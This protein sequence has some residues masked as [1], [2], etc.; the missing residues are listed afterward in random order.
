M[1]QDVETA[2]RKIR[3]GRNN[4]NGKS[5]SFSSKNGLRALGEKCEILK[6]RRRPREETPT[7]NHL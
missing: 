4:S 7:L 3:G 6:E 2:G 5:V 1:S